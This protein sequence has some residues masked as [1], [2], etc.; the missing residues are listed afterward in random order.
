M[1]VPSMAMVKMRTP[2]LAIERGIAA[3]ITTAFRQLERR[4]RCA[5]TILVTTNMRLDRKLLHSCATSRLSPGIEST[6]PFCETGTPTVGNYTLA[7]SA[8][9][10][11]QNAIVLFNSRSGSGT[12]QNKKQSGNS[13]DR[14]V[15]A[16]KLTANDPSHQVTSVTIL[17]NIRTSLASL[18]LTKPITAAT[19]NNASP[20]Q[21]SGF[22]SVRGEG[23]SVYMRARLIGIISKMCVYSSRRSAREKVS[24][25]GRQSAAREAAI[26]GPNFANGG[27]LLIG[28]R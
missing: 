6:T 18:K 26:S 17:Q 20:I 4:N 27:N 24:N 13:K 14:N 11:C 16:P 10:L 5:R 25:R 8:E 1:R 19:N 23:H 22:R 28:A 2:F 21:P 7:E 12:S 3:A 9:P 15:E